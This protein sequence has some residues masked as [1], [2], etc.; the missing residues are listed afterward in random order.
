MNVI[1]QYKIELSKTKKEFQE[2]KIKLARLLNELQERIN[3]FFGDDVKDIQAEEIEQIS[4]EL[5][6]V[7]NQAVELK[8]KIKKIEKELA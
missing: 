6:T 5:L 2:A 3:P 7:R 8:T 1:Q 4:G